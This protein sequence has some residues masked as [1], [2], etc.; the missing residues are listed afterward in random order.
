MLQE[1]V[2][3]WPSETLKNIYISSQDG[4]PAHMANLIQKL[5]KAYLRGCWDQQMWPPSSI[6]IK[7]MAFVFWSVLERDIS[8]RSIPRCGAAFLR[9]GQARLRL[10]IKAEAPDL[11]FSLLIMF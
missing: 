7:I 9:F 4:D 11:K 8:T 2:L 6:D 3:P 5:C 10:K 1:K